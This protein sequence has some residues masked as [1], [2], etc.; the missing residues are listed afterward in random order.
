MK[1]ILC[2]LAKLAIVCRNAGSLFSSKGGGTS[3][4]REGKSVY[5]E[6]RRTR[7][8]EPSA[9]SIAAHNLLRLTQFAIQKKCV[10]AQVRRSTRF[11][12]P[13]SRSER[14][15]QMLVRLIQPGQAQTDRDCREK[16]RPIRESCWRR[17]GKNLSDTILLLADGGEGQRSGDKLEAVRAMTKADGK[18]TAYVCEDFTCKAPVTDAGAL[19]KVLSTR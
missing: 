5:F 9:N 12:D 13:K 7:W 1:R 6:R 18:A 8:A 10:S 16:A 17:F 19:R 14:D 2:S 4:R 15:A 11:L 3:A